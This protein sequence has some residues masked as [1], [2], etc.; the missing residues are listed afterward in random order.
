MRRRRQPKTLIPL[1]LISRHKP[2]SDE[3]ISDED[4]AVFPNNAL[5]SDTIH[6]QELPLAVRLDILKG[7]S[8]RNLSAK[9]TSSSFEKPLEDE[10]EMPDFNEGEVVANSTDEENNSADR[11]NTAVTALQLRKYG[12]QS[13]RNKH[14]RDMTRI[15]E[16]SLH[17]KGS[18]SGS[19][20]TCPKANISGSRKCGGIGPSVPQIDSLP[21][22][23]KA[24]D[25]R[26]SGNLE[27][28]HLE[29]DD[30]IEV[31]SDTEPDETE[32]FP[33][34]FNLTSV[35]GVFN[36]L[37]DKA[38]QLLQKSSRPHLK[39]T[40]VDSE[41]FSE[42]VESGSSSDNE[43]SYQQIK[44]AFPV[45]KMQSMTELF[46]E[47]LGT[48]SVIIEGIHV[49]AHNSLSDGLSGK[50]QQMMLKEKETDMDFWKK[51]KT[52]ARPDS[53]LG[54]FDVKI[55]SR[56]HEGKLTV[57]HCSFGKCREV[58]P[59]CG[60]SLKVYYRNWIRNIRRMRFTERLNSVYFQSGRY[61]RNE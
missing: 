34:E 6:K 48:S 28:N 23:L 61:Y 8:D 30:K 22:I 60:R 7:I 53:E 42:P 47:A 54:C 45:K 5:S 41:D 44:N 33:H 55:L 3:S 58:R 13:I 50:L 32:V 31:N 46:L 37:Q 36:N 4:D 43:A 24:V 56:Y 17:Y 12:P 59:N 9:G 51:L 52:G 18:V 11:D 35:N 2:D 15:S 16:A 57:C 26:S 27:E 40:A 19:H 25:P 10:V 29:D 21:E 49:G 39:E 1:R 20:V 14:I 38:N